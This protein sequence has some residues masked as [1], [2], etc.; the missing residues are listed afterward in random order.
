MSSIHAFQPRRTIRR[1]EIQGSR[2]S[3]TIIIFPG[4][5]YE[6]TCDAGPADGDRDGLPD[7]APKS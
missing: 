3:A 4:V 6:R 5:R 2:E 1:R 7:T